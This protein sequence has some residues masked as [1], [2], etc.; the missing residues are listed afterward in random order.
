MSRIKDARGSFRPR[1]LPVSK[2]SIG[3]SPAQNPLS[4]A[5]GALGGGNNQ[6]N[7][8][9]SLLMP[10]GA[11][12]SGTTS[13]LSLQPKSSTAD[14]ESF[15]M[16]N[17]LD[18]NAAS[19][20]RK[21]PQHVQIAVME[22]GT[23]QDAQNPS[24]AVM[25]RIRDAKRLGTSV[26][27]VGG[28][29]VIEAS[30]EVESFILESGLDERA[31]RSFR[32]EPPDVQ[33]LVIERGSLKDCT[34]P[35]S[36]VMGRIKEARAGLMGGG[37]RSYAEATEDVENFIK[38]NGLDE[39]AA[40]YFRTEAPHVQQAVMSRGSL[41]DAQNPNSAVMGRIRDAKRGPPAGAGGSGGAGGVGAV[42]NLAS[43]AGAAGAAA[44]L[45]PMIS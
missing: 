4:G 12:A 5:L 6:M 44:V 11:A 28:A 38:E 3:P 8:L 36:A 24:S 29:A 10:G 43:L 16:E 41:A 25:S 17:A 18:E 19:A 27:T 2:P 40:Q 20:M 39:S 1:D 30:V 45:V 22:R 14:I 26:S 13:G 31:A 35:S 23:L 9:A 7:A 37:G 42:A 21:E 33:K 34:N 15:I 32:S